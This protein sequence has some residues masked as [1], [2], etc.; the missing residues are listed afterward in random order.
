MRRCV[1]TVNQTRVCDFIKFPRLHRV[2]AVHNYSLFGASVPPVR[3][4]INIEVCL[5]L[6]LAV[7]DLTAIA[8]H[9]VVS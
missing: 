8:V 6:I 2:H 3:E 9:Y 5:L 1:A 7:L 4:S